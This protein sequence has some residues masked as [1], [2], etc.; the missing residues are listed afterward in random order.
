MVLNLYALWDKKGMC[1][2]PMFQF[3]RDEEAKRFFSS[4]VRDMR[5]VVAQYPDDY[6]LDCLGVYDNCSGSIEGLI[7]PRFICP[8]MVLKQDVP[9]EVISN[10]KCE[11]KFS[12]CE[13]NGEAVRKEVN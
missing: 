9:P 7:R 1:F 5:S 2:G 6:E 8:V 4:V 3:G 13:A 10:G 11:D 12:G